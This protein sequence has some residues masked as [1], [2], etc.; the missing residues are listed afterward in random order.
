V[1]STHAACPADQW[2]YSGRLR[3]PGG[4]TA[5]FLTLARP[6]WFAAP[7]AMPGPRN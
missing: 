5:I 6:R 1:A 2:Q 7:A 4:G 3:R